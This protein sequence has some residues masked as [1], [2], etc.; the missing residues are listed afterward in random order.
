[1]NTFPLQMR[2]RTRLSVA[3]SQNLGDEFSCVK[4]QHRLPCELQREK[5]RQEV[6][7]F[8]ENIRSFFTVRVRIRKMYWLRKFLQGN[9]KVL[10]TG[11]SKKQSEMLSQLTGCSVWLLFRHRV[12]NSAVNKVSITPDMR[13]ISARLVVRHFNSGAWF[14]SSTRG[15]TVA[16]NSNVERDSHG[17]ST[18]YALL[19]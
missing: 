3:S 18:D 11:R 2:I 16:S 19:L 14:F 5:K 9:R 1:M 8:Y 15:S 10:Q 7:V 6:L 4:L 17:G 13:Q 12:V